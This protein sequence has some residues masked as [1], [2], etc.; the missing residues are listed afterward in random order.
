MVAAPQLR[1]LKK[2]AT[3]FVPTAVKRKKAAPEAPKF[4]AAPDVGS[5]SSDS[6]AEVGPARPDLLGALKN[7]F[8][9]KPV[10]KPKPSTPQQSDYDKFMAE[11]GDILG[12]Q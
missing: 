2:E 3:A 7:Q 12:P 6:N 9:S 1:D 4:N 5:S 11:M 8:G 10:E